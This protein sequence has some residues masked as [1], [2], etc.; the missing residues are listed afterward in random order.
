MLKAISSSLRFSYSKTILHH[1]RPLH[2]LL[3]HSSNAND[4]EQ[5]LIEC[6]NGCLKQSSSSRLTPQAWIFLPTSSL[7]KSDAIANS[8]QFIL[9]QKNLPLIGTYVDSIDR[10]ARV[11]LILIASSDS[12]THPPPVS[13]YVPSGQSLDESTVSVGH[14]HTESIHSSKSTSPISP[15]SI[16]AIEDRLNIMRTFLLSDAVSRSSLKSLET[17]FP[18][19]E[20]IGILGSWFV[21]STRYCCTHLNKLQ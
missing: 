20:H 6:V 16:P 1:S 15:S 17:L 9:S 10:E 4:T 11:A 3:S 21:I 2:H 19:S 18:Q 12:H 14:W 13:F 5:A 7:T 8:P